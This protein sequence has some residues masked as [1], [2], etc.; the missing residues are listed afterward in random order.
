MCVCLCVCVYVFVCVRVCL[1]V[2]VCL[3]VF[4]MDVCVCARFLIG[5]PTLPSDIVSP[6]RL[7]WVKG[8]YVFRCNL[9]PA[10]L[11]ARGLLLGLGSV[12]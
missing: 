10:L 4:A 1:C 9:P 8:V 6:L 12:G 3:F 5:S 7:R 2:C 11:A